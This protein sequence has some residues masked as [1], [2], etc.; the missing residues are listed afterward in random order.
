MSRATIAKRKNQ[1]VAIRAALI[2]F[3]TYTMVYGFRKGFTVCSFEGMQ[4]LGINYKVWLVISQVLGYASSKFYG[5]RFIS[6]LKKTGRGKII[7]L[8]VG[9]SWSGLF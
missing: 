8:L 5:I 6:E 9:I 7:L 4:F 1:H 2:T 3:L